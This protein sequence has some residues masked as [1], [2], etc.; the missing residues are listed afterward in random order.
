MK[1]NI[2]YIVTFLVFWVLAF[3][4]LSYVQSQKKKNINMELAIDNFQKTVDFL[5][6]NYEWNFPTPSWDLILLDDTNS[7]IHLEN[8]D[9]P[10]SEIKNLSVIQWTTCDILN[11]NNDFQQINYD[12]RFSIIDKNWKVLHKRC[13]SYSVT[14]DKKHFQVSSIAQKDWKYI[15][16]TAWNSPKSISKSYNS[17]ALVKDQNVDFLPYPP[18]KIS[19][20]ISISNIQDS[21]ISINIEPS[22]TVAYKINAEEWNNVLIS[23]NSQTY[24]ISITWK[25]NPKTIVKFI[26]TN[27]SILHINW[28]KTN[29][30]ISFQLKD[31]SI[32]SQKIDYFVETWRFL[33]N[34]VKL[35]WSKDMTIK[36]DWVTLII[37]WTRFTISAQDEE[38]DTFLSLW[39]L[40]QKLKWG[41]TV[42]LDMDDAFSLIKS[43]KFINDLTKIKWLLSFSVFTDIYANK[44]QFDKF[45]VRKIWQNMADAISGSNDLQRFEISYSNWQKIWLVILKKPDSFLTYLKQNKWLL[46][47]EDDLKYDTDYY[48]DVVNQFCKSSN[49]TNWLDISKFYYILDAWN[50]LNSF[51]LK[52]SILDATSLNKYILYSNRKYNGQ[53]SN[54][55]YLDGI[56]KTINSLPWFKDLDYWFW[57]K[58]NHL[59]FACEI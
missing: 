11:K 23:D 4:Y 15:A 48:K 30:E 45:T 1:K 46:W 13:F 20:I 34:I 57:D 27:W 3:S 16:L 25:V 2:L 33:A 10:L 5:Q 14:V 36:K 37:R 58:F 39:S 19:P 54:R 44:L 7:M 17:V 29:Q 31:Y 40:V 42:N 32:D 51:N 22:E 56:D 21:K 43:N 41:K 35:D 28:D 50:N 12:P 24:D 55:V 26:D 52:Q 47:I 6:Q 9:T 59:V 49:F 38:F 53:N 18:S 8:R